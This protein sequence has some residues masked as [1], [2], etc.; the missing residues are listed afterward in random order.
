MPPVVLAGFS[1]EEVDD[2]NSRIHT[3]REAL[4]W[5]SDNLHPRVAKAAS[6]GAEDAAI[7][8]MMIRVN[9]RYRFFTLD[10]GRLPQETYDAMDRARERYGIKLEVLLPDAGEVEEMVGEH[11]VN[12]FYRSVEN[13]RLCCR[14]RK[15]HPIDR[16]LGTL[17]GWITGLRREQSEFRSDAKMFEVD[18]M[19][20]G[21]LKI[22]P[23][24]DWTWDRVWRYVKE[25]D[26]PYNKLLDAGYPS[27]GCAPCTRA[28]QPGQ[29]ARS[30]RWWWEP[31]TPK[32]CGLHMDHRG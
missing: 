19:H 4:Q 21:I 26:V 23:L 9:P 13:R 17:D 1:Q 15:V 2:L 18:K 31:E 7:M 24:V 25:N 3:A 5:A 11:G 8:D 16:I 20:G 22:N 29:S 27:I 30:G 32:E 10:T 14:I 12:L 28:I 6:F